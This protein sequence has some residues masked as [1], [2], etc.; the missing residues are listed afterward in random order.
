M[1]P[2]KP[3][4]ALLA[5]AR[6]T[7][8][9]DLLTPYAILAESGAV[10][11]KIVGATPEPVRLTPGV[12]WVA[13]Q[14]TRGE[15]ADETRPCPDVVIVP[16]L[17]VV[18]DTA[19]SAWLRQQA[20]RGARLMSVCEGAKVLAAA[21]LLRG[22][23]ATV[24]W[25]SRAKL[26][27]AYP[28]VTW[29]QDRRWVIDGPITTTAGISAVEPATLALLSD[30]AG[31]AC[32][33]DTADRLRLPRPDQR[34]RGADFR[35]TAKGGATVLRNRLAFWRHEAVAVRLSDGVDEM[36]LAAELDAWSRTYR[37]TAWAVGPRSV[38]SRHGLTLSRAPLLPRRFHREIALPGGDVWE[39]TFEQIRH[40]YGAPTACFVALQFEHPY[41]AIR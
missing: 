14:L 13:P 18:E 24:H 3:F 8:A 41:G 20:A 22:R 37:S 23:E 12:A 6:G 21:G 7:E 27:R 36:G 1:A 38:T 9:P 15:L 2:R 10:D 30:L 28:D 5:D 32:M 11:V 19:R 16:A 31:E 39:S 4:V 34:H 35:V 29:R 33:R 17:D 25:Y 40:A 26:A